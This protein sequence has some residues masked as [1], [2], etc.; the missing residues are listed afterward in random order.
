MTFASPC[1]MLS[2]CGVPYQKLGHIAGRSNPLPKA[3][4]GT[5]TMIEASGGSLEIVVDVRF[6]LA[7]R[8]AGLTG[9]GAGSERLLDDGLHRACTAATFDAATEAAIDLP[10]IARKI[11]RRADG[12]AD[13][14]VAED[15]AGTNDHGNLTTLR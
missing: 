13:I 8:A 6:G 1:M 11:I 12:A 3:R 5:R 7:V 2:R 4:T 9:L 14:V 15:V 10:G